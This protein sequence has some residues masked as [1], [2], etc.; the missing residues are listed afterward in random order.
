MAKTVSAP[1]GI[2]IPQGDLDLIDGAI[3]ANPG[4]SRT[5]VFRTAIERFIRSEAFVQLTGGQ[6]ETPA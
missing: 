1:F 6:K 4:L 2:R 5:K 3:A